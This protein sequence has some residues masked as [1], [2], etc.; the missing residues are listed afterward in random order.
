MTNGVEICLIYC[1]V[2]R[3]ERSVGS[4]RQAEVSMDPQEISTF[5]SLKPPR[6]SGGKNVRNSLFLDFKSYTH[7]FCLRSAS[8]VAEYRNVSTTQS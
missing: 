8:R 2:C 3:R 5:L 7:T 1:E 6:T 4:K